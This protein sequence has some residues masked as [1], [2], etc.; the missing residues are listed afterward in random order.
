MLG[1]QASRAHARLPPVHIAC[2]EVC[3]MEGEHLVTFPV[4]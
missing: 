1:D 2:Y 3:T 4:Q